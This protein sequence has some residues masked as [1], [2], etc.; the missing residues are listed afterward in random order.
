MAKMS[1]ISP[2]ATSAKP[3]KYELTALTHPVLMPP[4]L[5]ALDLGLQADERPC[6]LVIN[7]VPTTI[8]VRL[9]A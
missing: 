5:M 2:P 4:T 8:E 9:S 1:T 3:M 7:H 6:P